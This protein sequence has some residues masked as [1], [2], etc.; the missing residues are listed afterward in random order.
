MRR[1]YIERDAEGKPVR[2][3]LSATTCS[4]EMKL[5][6][7]DRV[8]AFA[9]WEWEKTG[10]IGDNSQFYKP[11]TVRHFYFRDG[12]YLADLWFDCGRIS[13]GH[14]AYGLKLLTSVS[15]GDL[16]DTESAGRVT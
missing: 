8:R 11:A 10:D 3:Y 1:G 15:S 6:R 14:F 12:E 9:H 4:P 5:K 13:D 7:G 16:A 2:L